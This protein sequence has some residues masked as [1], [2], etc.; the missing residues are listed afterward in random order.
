MRLFSYTTIG[1]S[2]LVTVTSIIIISSSSSIIT[3]F[4]TCS[5][6]NIFFRGRGLSVEAFSAGRLPART[7]KV[8]SVQVHSA[9]SSLWSRSALHIHQHQQQQKQQQQQ[10]YHLISSR[11][12]RATLLSMSSS[13]LSSSSSQLLLSNP[14]QVQHVS[15]T[16]LTNSTIRKERTKVLVDALPKTSSSTS[17]AEKEKGRSIF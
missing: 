3:S 15:D 17:D 4:I 14:P 11:R 13:T 8:Q 10:Q 16:Y 6:S 7:A 9:S 5:S 1:S 12:N 2:I